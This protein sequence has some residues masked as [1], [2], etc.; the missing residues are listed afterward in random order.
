[1]GPIKRLIRRSRLDERLGFAPDHRH[2]T[3]RPY[4]FRDLIL[5]RGAVML[6]NAAD[7]DLLDQVKYG[8]D[9]MFA[10]Y[11]KAPAENL[12]HSATDGTIDQSDAWNQV[13]RSHIYDPA[14]KEFTGLSY[15][16][17]IR[18]SGLWDLAASAFPESE[19]GESSQC[20]CR[21]A[22]AGD[23]QI[24]FDTPTEFHVDAQFH[25]I[26]Q[27][28]INFWTPLTACGKDSPGLKIILLGLQKTR[29]Y[30]D[31]SE[32]GYEPGPEDIGCMRHFRC[33]KE[34]LDQ[35]EEHGLAKCIWVPEFRK[36]DIL[37]FTNFTMH[38]THCLPDMTKPRTSVEVRVNLPTARY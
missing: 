23:L 30:L 24:F 15:F 16:E 5:R 22:M 13:K 35:L 11:A 1:M 25:S 34:R 4:E 8:I 20:T 27:L 26:H 17:I 18:R 2:G 10:Q 32:V 9:G 7:P 37:A 36:G 21:R 19:V 3:L 14:F 12:A 29:S 33:S 38:A 6:R 31:F 28:S